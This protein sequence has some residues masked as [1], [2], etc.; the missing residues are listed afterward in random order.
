MIGRTLLNVTLALIVIFWVIPFV[1]LLIT[2]LRD[3]KHA[4]ETGFWRGLT[5]NEIGYSLKTQG[6]EGVVEQDGKYVISGNL[7][8]FA[9]NMT[10]N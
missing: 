5:T 2:S 4:N 9:T 6:Q 1:G 7:L 8:T 10:A 3:T